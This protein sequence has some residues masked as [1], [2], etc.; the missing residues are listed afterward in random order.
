MLFLK[1]SLS[2][3]FISI[4]YF[5]LKNM[6]QGETVYFGCFAFFFSNYGIK[7][8]LPLA[9]NR[10]LGFVVF[11]NSILLVGHVIESLCMK[12]LT[13]ALKTFSIP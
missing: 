3:A 9:M 7:I 4:Q 10:S 5:V 8:K 13:V 12:T 6:I 11:V 2:G 1:V